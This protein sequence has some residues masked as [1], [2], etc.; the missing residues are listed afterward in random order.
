MQ[1]MS[2]EVRRRI[3][4]VCGLIALLGLNNHALSQAPKLTSPKSHRHLRIGKSVAV[5]IPEFSMAETSLDADLKK[6]NLVTSR[7]RKYDAFAVSGTRLFVVER[8]TER[9]FEICGLPLEWRPFSN[10]TWADNQTLMFD[11]WSQPHYGVHY[12]V[13]V[14]SRKLLIAAPFPDKFYLEQQR[15]ERHNN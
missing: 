15:P 4:P 11:R 14:K 13:N 8:G 2:I 12:A 9:V 3:I 1:K 7:N 6:E 10:F 5:D